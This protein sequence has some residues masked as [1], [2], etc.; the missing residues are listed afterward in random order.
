MGS[1]RITGGAVVVDAEAE[2]RDALRPQWP[3][4][5]VERSA[6]D[7]APHVSVAALRAVAEA[8]QCVAGAPQV[9]RVEGF[10]SRE[11]PDWYQLLLVVEKPGA[12]GTDDWQRALEAAGAVIE[13][14]IQRHPE[15]ADAIASQISFDL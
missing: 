8:A 5:A 9:A 15:M 12:P 14:A 7:V 1:M 6:L 13:A 10:R 3:A 2:L 11:D 4:A